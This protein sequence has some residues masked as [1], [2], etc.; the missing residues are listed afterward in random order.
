M[1]CASKVRLTIPICVLPQPGNQEQVLKRRHVEVVN[2]ALL[3]EDPGTIIRDDDEISARIE[4]RAIGIPPAVTEAF[5]NQVIL[6]EDA[7]NI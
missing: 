2:R 5:T 1:C 6:F 4:I 3:D 7:G